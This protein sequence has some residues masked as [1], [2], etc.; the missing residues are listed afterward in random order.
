MAT[1]K[2]II[3]AD[4]RVQRNPGKGVRWEDAKSAASD[5]TGRFA[6]IDIPPG[7]YRVVASAT[8]YAPRMLGYEQLKDGAA[9]KLTV[10]LSRA[11]KFTGTVT[12]ADGRPVPGVTVRTSNTMGIDGRGYAP[13]DAPE[14][15]SDAQGH[16]VL[17]DLPAGYLQGWAHAPGYFHVDGL[18]LYA[19]PDP[20]SVVLRVVATGSI[21]GKVVDKT[22][23]P[24]SGGSVNVAPPGDP[25]GKWGG[26][27][28]AAADG[29]FEFKDVPPG[30]YTVSTRP[31]LPG[32]PKDPSAVSI[33]VISGKV[34]E[35]TVTQ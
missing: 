33:E 26:S 27:M 32:L 25:I 13:P 31:Q 10:E 35:V 22:G 7:N 6:L 12:D 4:L 23:R 18:K 9:R 8:G 21:R 14:T 16:F 34:A 24:T 17:A 5:A 29:T 19:L 3:S 15:M 1:G 30:P 11:A 2:P 20:T 28:N